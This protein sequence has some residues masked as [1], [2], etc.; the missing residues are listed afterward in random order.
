MSHKIRKKVFKLLKVIIPLGIGVFLLWHFYNSMDDN[1]KGIFF[2]ALKEANY[3]WIVFSVL[4][5]LISHIIRAYRWK[6]MLEPLGYH[7]KFKH[8]F[9]AVMSGYLINLLIPRAGEASRA[10]L[11]YNSDQVP[12]SKSVGT[13]ISERIFDTFTLGIFLLITLFVSFQD[14]INVKDILVANHFEESESEGNQ[15]IL[16]IFL[17]LLIFGMAI[18]SILWIKL[19]TFRS[20]LKKFITELIFGVFAIFKSKKPFHFIGQTFLIWMLYLLYFAVCFYAFEETQ[21]FPIRGIL[22][23]FIA[24]TF[25][26]AFTNGGVGAYPYLVGIV[27]TYYIGAEL[28]SSE[29]AEGI[30]KALGMIIWVAQTLMM[31]VIGLLSLILIPKNFKN[32]KN[33]QVGTNTK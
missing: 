20:K 10:A 19:N 15:F 21:N 14:L 24:G 18:L 31:I 22:I 17:S 27:V 30:G 29:Q 6:Y 25:G 2:K 23:G 13:I 7:T 5:G 8:R 9:Y 3:F 32:N 1:T 33:E 16:T 4:L 28:D 11:L 12:F 26:I